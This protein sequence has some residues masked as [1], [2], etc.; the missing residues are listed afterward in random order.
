MKRDKMWPRQLYS[1]HPASRNVEGANLAGLSL[2]QLALSL[3]V[4]VSGNYHKTL[5]CMLNV[6]RDSTG[7]MFLLMLTRRAIY[8]IIVNLHK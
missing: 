4:I 6:S 2:L 7:L 8:P 1:L 3:Q 5:Y